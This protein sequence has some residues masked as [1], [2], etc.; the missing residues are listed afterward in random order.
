[1][2]LA[3]RE[4][5]ALWQIDWELGR[6]ASRMHADFWAFNQVCS[7]QA[8][9]RQERIVHWW[10]PLWCALR[11]LLAP[12]VFITVVVAGGG[13][14]HARCAARDCSGHTACP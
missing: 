4:Q 10:G 1:M 2:T 12:A 5:Q 8:M 13:L 9:P 3:R 6:S 7:A 14:D 11:Q